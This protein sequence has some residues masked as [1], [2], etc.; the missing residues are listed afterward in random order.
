MFSYPHARTR[1]LAVAIG[2]CALVLAFVPHEVHAGAADPVTADITG[3]ITDSASGQPL[4]GA[5]ITILSGDQVVAVTTADP[6]GRFLIH[7]IAEGAYTVRVRRLGFRAEARSL[8]VR[9]G[10]TR[11]L[12]FQL[13]AAPVTL[14]QIQVSLAVPIAIDTRSG[15]QQYQEDEYHGAPTNTT[16]QIL[17]QVIT[18]AA[19][20]PTGEVHIRGQHAEYT[21]YLDGIPV[22]PGISG[23]LNEIFDPAV[24]DRIT[25]LT[26]GWD[27]EYGNRN[28][29]IVAIQTKVPAG[30][31]HFGA[32]LYGGSYASNGQSLNLSSSSGAWGF[33]LAATR[34]ATDMRQYPVAYD[35][36]TFKPFNYSNQGT[37]VFGFAKLT[38]TPSAR[39]LFY[40]EGNASGTNFQIPFDS[41]TGIIQDDQK[42]RNNFVN[43]GWRHLTGSP[44][45]SPEEPGGELFTG[46]FFRNGSLVYTPGE[47]D[48]PSFVFFPDTTPYNLREDRNFQTVGLTANYAFRTGHAFSLKLGTYLAHTTGHEDFT[49]FDAMGNPGPVSNADLNGGDAD[50]Y[51]QS[52][53]APAEWYDLHLGLRYDNHAAPFAGHQEQWSP[54]VRVNFYPSSSTTFYAYYGKLFMPTNVEDLRSITSVADSNVVT[55]PTL[56]ERDDFYELGYVQRFDFGMV[57]KL[58]GYYKLSS[59]GIDDQTVPGSA[60]VTSVN[61]A[62]V[63]IKGIEATFEIKPPGA[64]SGYVNFSINHAYGKAPITG[65]FFPVDTTAV[66]GGWFDLDHDQRISSVA[67]VVFSAHQLYA[68]VTGI[69]G[70]GLTNGADITAPI[71]TGLTS[72]NRDIHVAPNFIANLSLGYTFLWGKSVLRPE[73]FIDNLFDSQYLLKGQFFSGASAGRPR[74]I[75]LQLTYNM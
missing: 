67:S 6:F 43:L 71:G 55:Q 62:E 73:L 40:L 46:V 3:H 38:Y 47:N 69:Y 30:A 13:V 16:S 37:D 9:G 14:A 51:I 39:D 31:F 64:W 17:Q 58:S 44:S 8:E 53:V 49:T 23:S 66:P 20:A 27:A 57:M 41:A 72:F 59:P 5:Q 18:G 34:Q 24:V 45:A 35:T 22:S 54:R 70:S 28:A 29:A 2:A 65:G 61:I 75:Q 74:T 68:S 11:T 52:V 36:L 4:Q 26:G 1:A 10:A 42:D 19:R 21:Y 25:F 7:N 32:S 33:Y 63:R 56:P 48:D 15:D 50:G 12:D 60:I